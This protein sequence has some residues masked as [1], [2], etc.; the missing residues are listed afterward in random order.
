MKL[1]E[2]RQILAERNLQLTKSL[3]QNFLHDQNQLRRIADAAGIGPEDSVLEIGPGLGPL[4]DLLLERAREVLAIEMDER[5]VDVLREKYAERTNLRLV[6]DDALAYVREHRQWGAWKMAANLPYSVASPI[7]VELAEAATPPARIAA[8]L[9]WEVAQRIIASADDEHYGLLSL[10]IQLRYEPM[11]LFKIPATCFFPEPEVGSA[12]VT[13]ER[14]AE[15]VLD[16][17]L[18]PL[19]KRVVKCAFSQR[20]KMMFKLLKQFWP[21]DKLVAA[22]ETLGLSPQIRAEKVALRQFAALTE[23]L[24]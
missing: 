11:G 14:R 17:A 18:H 19:F 8:T 20:R 10:M 16:P 21:A 5:L 9:Q 4:T 7:L 1:S 12:C 24:A 22:F 15:P 2:I 6:H 13:L 23:F 3:G